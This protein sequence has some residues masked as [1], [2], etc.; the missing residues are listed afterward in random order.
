MTTQPPSSFFFCPS[1]YFLGQTCQ[2]RG[3]V[4]G[5]DAHGPPAAPSPA[6]TY[7]RHHMTHQWPWESVAASLG[8]SLS[9]CEW[10]LH[11]ALASVPKHLQNPK[12]K[13][14]VQGPQS[15]HIPCPPPRA[16]SPFC[17]F[18][19]FG[20]DSAQ[21][22]PL[23]WKLPWPTLFQGS[24]YLCHNPYEQDPITGSINLYWVLLWTQLSLQLVNKILMQN[25]LD[26]PNL[27]PQ[28]VTLSLTQ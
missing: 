28:H 20:K 2:V 23:L 26:L 14:K 21:A 7:G 9:P 4:S 17:P 6:K 22:P 11:S 27:Y 19:D 13:R 5:Q 8:L 16:P 18:N 1:F 15:L 10:V 12:H 24:L 25:S 3:A